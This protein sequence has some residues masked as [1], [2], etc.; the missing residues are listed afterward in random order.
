MKILVKIAELISL[1]G[2][3]AVSLEGNGE[4]EQKGKSRNRKREYE[5]EHGRLERWRVGAHDQPRLYIRSFAAGN[6]T[7]GGERREKGRG[8]RTREG[9]EGWSRY[10]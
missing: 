9:E 7:K 6:E 2:E 10:G 8:R 3:L 4:G 5:R 1:V